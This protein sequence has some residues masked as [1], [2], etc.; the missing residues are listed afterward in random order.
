VAIGH[1]A[2]VNN[3][4]G[5]PDATGI[6]LGNNAA[7]EYMDTAIGSG[8]TNTG[9]YAFALGTSANTSKDYALALG[10]N[11]SVTFANAVALGAGSAT[12]DANTGTSAQKI[13]LSGTTYNFYGLAN[14]TNGTVSVGKSGAARQL[15]N[16][17]AGDVSATSTDAVNGSQLYALSNEVKSAAD[18]GFTVAGDTD[19]TGSNVSLGSKLTIKGN[20]NT[21]TTGYSTGNVMT[22]ASG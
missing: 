11:S 20:G 3:A 8:A 18:N 2:T 9:A 1:N 16:V 4:A 5:K 22:S 19:T 13:T 15:Q 17:A 7:A 10:A 12:T 21:D 14:S 6:A